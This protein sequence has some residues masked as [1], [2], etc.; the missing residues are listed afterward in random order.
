MSVVYLYDSVNQANIP[1]SAQIVGAYTDGAFANVAAAKQYHPNAFIVTITVFG[2]HNQGAM[3]V[4]CETGDVTP[5]AAAVWASAERQAGRY[6][7]IYTSVS[8]IS[9]VATQLQQHGLHF[10]TDPNDAHGVYL[11]AAGYTNT[12][13]LCNGSVATQW[14]DAGPYDISD[15]NGVWP[16]HLLPTNPPPPSPTPVNML[17]NCIGGFPTKDGKGYYLIQA[18]GGVFS[19]GDAAF[20]GSLGSAKLNAP[21]VDGALTVSGNGY[22]LVGA[23]GGVFCFGDAKFFGSTGNVKLAQPIVELKVTPT[24]NGYWLVAADGGVFNFG[25]AGFYGSGA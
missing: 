16:Y 12:P 9:N 10:S 25:D 21:I 1:A 7:T 13:Y 24:G 8:N 23:D 14:K 22:Y 18:D 17:T 6:P 20:H 19:H 2:S 5:V 11:W 4:D 3:V 15:T